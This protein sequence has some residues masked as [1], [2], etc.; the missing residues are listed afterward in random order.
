MNEGRGAH[1][2]GENASRSPTIVFLFL[3]RGCELTFRL[4]VL[5]RLVLCSSRSPAQSCLGA[6]MCFPLPL[7]ASRLHLL[8]LVCHFKEAVW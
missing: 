6:F 2:T 5:I 8:V 3:N 7:K 1:K 4:S